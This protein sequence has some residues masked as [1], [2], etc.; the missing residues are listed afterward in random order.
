MRT[1]SFLMLAA[2]GVSS[3]ACSSAQPPAVY[4]SGGDMSAPQPI[5]VGVS[6]ATPNFPNVGNMTQRVPIGTGIV[7]ADNVG[8]SQGS[9]EPPRNAGPGIVYKAP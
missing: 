3:A 9:M 7:G 1:T 8:P 2:L 4:G 6:E 5:G